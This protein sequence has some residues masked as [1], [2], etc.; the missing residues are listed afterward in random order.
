MRIDTRARERLCSHDQAARARCPKASRIGFGRIVVN[1]K[2]YLSPGGET[3]VAWSI[4]AYLGTPVRPDAASIVLRAELLGADRVSQ[5]LAPALG[6]S[7]PSVSVA[8]GRVVRR[9]SGPY[10]L[11]ARFGELP[12]GLRVPSSMTATHTRLELAIGAVRRTRQDFVRHV[13]VRTLSGYETQEIPDHRL[14]G[15]DLL[16][17]PESCRVSW[18]YEMRVGFPSGVVRTAG[19]LICENDR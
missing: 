13:R 15:Y 17:S 4:G 18:P 14:V 11:E 3:E 12:G 8:T 6:T 1:V 19:R 5:L 16:R 2:G 9:P 7:V 10:G